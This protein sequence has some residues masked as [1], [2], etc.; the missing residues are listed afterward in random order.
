MEH[1]MM[2]KLNLGNLIILGIQ[3]TARDRKKLCLEHARMEDKAGLLG[4]MEDYADKVMNQFGRKGAAA[5]VQDPFC[6]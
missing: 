2:S 5:A 1:R 4:H 3:H 6:Y